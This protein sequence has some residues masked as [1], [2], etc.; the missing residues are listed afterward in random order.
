MAAEQFSDRASD[1]AE[2]QDSLLSG[3]EGIKQETDILKSAQRVSALYRQQVDISVE[4]T[5]FKE[6]LDDAARA[7][8]I[9]DEEYDS[10]SASL[11][12]IWDKID[13]KPLLSYLGNRLE[14][15]VGLDKNDPRQE[16]YE[17]AQHGYETAMA[18][19]QDP[20]IDN[21]VLYGVFNQCLEYSQYTQDADGIVRRFDQFR[22][23]DIM[24]NDPD[25]ARKWL[26]GH[27]DVAEQY[28][29][30]YLV[31]AERPEFLAN[32]DSSPLA[33]LLLA[34]R[35]YGL[36]A[37]T[38]QEDAYR[39]KIRRIAKNTGQEEELREAEAEFDALTDEE[40]AEWSRDV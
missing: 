35:Q 27:P 40:L 5:D 12:Q 18:L 24:A 31:A 14:E 38:G 15:E 11:S 36:L 32:S 22:T 19:L 26:A 30:V 16:T 21:A 4:R 9:S 39:G 37:A 28:A 8:T 20:E 2:Q 17:K 33:R 1:M 10:L 7:K 23:S 6:E 29:E 3:I 13:W 34:D 25:V